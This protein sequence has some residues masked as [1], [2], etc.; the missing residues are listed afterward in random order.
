[1]RDDIK[2]LM[3]NISKVIVGKED[4]VKNIIA[5]LLCGGHVLIEDVPGVG[6]TRLVSALATSLDGEFNRIQLTPD[7]M[8]S[9]IT[10]YSIPDS[11]TGELI[12]HPGVS[13]CNFL[14]ADEINRASSKAQSALLEIMEEHQITLDGSTHQ[15]PE[16]FMV[17]ATQ[18]HIETYGTYHLP[19]AQ[20]DR[21]IM[22]V[23]MGYPTPEEEKIILDMEHIR[24]MDIKKVLDTSDIVTMQKEVTK[25]T[26]A[27]SLK[28]YIIK[29]VAAT[30]TDSNITLGVSPRGSIGLYNAAKAKAFIDGRDYVTPDDIKYMIHPVLA[31]RIILSASG[32]ANFA[33][34]HQLLD[35][36]VN[37]IEVPLTNEI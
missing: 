26:M 28:N 25:V 2:I 11:V 22:R 33:D 13:I 9:D 15:L 16:V 17:L 5:A 4:T 21:F 1:M 24:T 36:I 31:H 18:N 27:E 6:K 30:R 10:G 35:H 7:I 3:D 37:S 34:E 32:R 8:P 14:L 12:Y 29:L 20:M 23:T 19:E